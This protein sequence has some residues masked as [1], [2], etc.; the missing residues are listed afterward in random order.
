[1][2]GSAAL[3]FIYNFVFTGDFHPREWWHLGAE[4]SLWATEA[5]ASLYCVN[6]DRARVHPV[7]NNKKKRGERKCQAC[8]LTG[9]SG[10]TPF[11]S[12]SP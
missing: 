3:E 5:L 7:W 2:G 12:I 4:V 9:V 8:V 6:G 1:M 10:Q 11:T